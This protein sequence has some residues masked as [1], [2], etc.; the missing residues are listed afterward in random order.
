MKLD[1]NKVIGNYEFDIILDV[2]RWA[3]P[4]SVEYIRH[5]YASVQV[6]CL[7]TTFSIE[8]SLYRGINLLENVFIKLYKVI[9]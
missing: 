6:L 3:L 1:I 2:R 7:L 4:L 9:F 8:L 5:W